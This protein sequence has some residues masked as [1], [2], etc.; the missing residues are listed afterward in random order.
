MASTVSAVARFGVMLGLAAMLT[1]PALPQK[2]AQLNALAR[3][4]PG[5][6]QIREIGQRAAPQAICVADPDIL[7]QVQHRGTPC[8]RLV[9]ANEPRSATVHYTCPAHGFGRTSVRV[10]TSRLAKID[11]QGILD[12]TPFAYRA[13]A[14]RVGACGGGAVKGSR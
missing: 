14:R 9:I 12:N 3:L 13:E 5:L 1:S 6:W 10:E 8:S 7:T 2:R 4:E 11:T